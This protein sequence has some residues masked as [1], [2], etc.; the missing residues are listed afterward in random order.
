MGSLL[1][2]MVKTKCRTSKQFLHVIDHA[3]SHQ[4]LSQGPMYSTSTCFSLQRQLVGPV[5]TLERV[6]GTF[7]GTFFFILSLASSSNLCIVATSSVV[8]LVQDP[9]PAKKANSRNDL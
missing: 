3:Y 7:L 6:K 4:M 1:N 2:E 9:F 5:D 8:V